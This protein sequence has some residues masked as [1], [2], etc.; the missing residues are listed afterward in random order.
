M[1]WVS[2]P[3]HFIDFEGG[4]GCGVLEYGVVTLREGRI[5]AA[6]GRLCAPVGR[7]PTEDIAVHGLAPADLAGAKPLADDWEW[8]AGLRADAPFAAH[9]AGVE[10]GLIRSVWPTP[11]P[12][13]DFIAMGGRIADWGPWIDTARL[14]GEIRPQIA[15]LGLESLVREMALQSTLDAMAATL[16][17]D[18]RRH[19]HAARYDALAGALLLAALALEPRCA[20]LS[21]GQLLL[22]STRD[23]AKRQAMVQPELF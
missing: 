1:A 13:A 11:R 14:Y 19:Y 9:F 20:G 21:V 8:F 17:P 18:G 4:L 5:E 16:C 12:S 23:P 2:Q 22:L 10:N 7:I 3:I 6:Q 15:S